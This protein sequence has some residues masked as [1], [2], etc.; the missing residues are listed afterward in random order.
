MPFAVTHVLSS[1]I[2]VDLYRDYLTKHKK[3]FTLHTIFF[4]GLGGL[5]PDIDIPLGHVLGWFGLE[6]G[7]RTI[8]HTP[9]FA[10]LFLIPGLILWMQNGRR[11]KT[12]KIALYLFVITF[13]IAMHLLLDFV[14]APDMAG[15]LVPFYPFSTA[16]YSMGLLG[17]LSTIQTMSIFAAI[18]AT[19]LILWLWHEEWRHKIRDYI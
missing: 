5:L 12:G 2:A 3:Y 1:I 8:T 18:D 17:D 9:F 11:K 6:L 19:L 13:G 15:G 10:L 4:A 16:E 7:H 14:L